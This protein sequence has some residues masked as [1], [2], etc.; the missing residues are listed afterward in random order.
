M[1]EA[2]TRKALID[3]LLK[4]AGWDVADH[5]LVG[6]EIPVAGE[7]AEPWDGVTDY[8]LKDDEGKIL[9]VV[10]AKRSSRHPQDAKEQLRRYIHDIARMQ[11]QYQPFGFMTNGRDIWFWDVQEGNPRRVAGFFTK[12][13]LANR[14]FLREN[15][16]PFRDVEVSQRIVDRPYQHE[17]IRR[18]TEAFE[19]G[20]RRALIVMATGAGK[21]RTTMGLIDLCIRSHQ[22]RNVL[23]LADRDALVDQALKDG[24]KPYLPD[25]PRDRIYSRHID[26]T[27]RL[28]VATEQTMNIVY[29]EFSPGFF[30]LIVLDE[31]HRSIFKRFTEVVD[32]FDARMVGLTA[33]PATY[34]DRNSFRVFDCENTPTFLYAYEDAVRDGYL[35]DFALYK[36]QTGFQRSG[37]K[38]A[39]LSEE[40][41]NA[42]IERGIDPDDIDYSGSDLEKRVS[43]KDTLRKQWQEIMDLV[44]K[45]QSGQLPAK[46][47]VFSITQ[48]HAN[49][50]RDVFEEMYPQFKDLVQVIT[51]SVERVRDGSYGDGLLTKFKNNDKPRIAISVDML[52][53]GVDVPEVVNLVFMKPVQSSI[54]LWQMI[55][56]GTRSQAACRFLERLPEGKKKDFRIIDFW[57]NRFNKK[58][59]DAPPPE[60]PVLVR[61]FNTRLALVEQTISDTRNPVYQQAVT[62]L[63]QM[64]QRISIESFP[65]RKV[66]DQVETAW[67]EGFWLMLTPSKIEFLRLNIGPLLR[68]VPKVDPAAEG[69]TNRIEGVRLKALKGDLSP[70]ALEPAIEDISRLPDDIITR[71][72]SRRVLQEVLTIDAISEAP[73]RLNEVIDT[74]A[75]HMNRRRQRVNSFLMLDL[76]DKIAFSGLI[77]IGDGGK[78]VYVEEYKKQVEERILMI[79]EN[80]PVIQAIRQGDEPNRADL[81]ELER[82]LHERLDDN[83]LHL[84]R[85]NIRRIY[86]YQVDGFLGFLGRVMQIEGLPDYSAVVQN[87]FTDFIAQ[88]KFSADQIRFLRAVQDV[89]LQKR[90]LEEADLYEAPLTSF[91]INA[92][93][94]FFSQDQIE[95]IIKL[96][97]ELAA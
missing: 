14:K 25:E 87:S 91:G 70:D 96:T 53:T 7:D 66:W 5:S 31:A 24:I 44:Y 1:N 36:A 8:I 23:F 83:E 17:A 88:N 76:Q 95:S 94:K 56:R 48:Q 46:T 32:Y 29:K 68:Y 62:S 21:T 27:K 10:E 38:G 28:F 75:R 51:S 64:I 37:I 72:E 65:V 41:R 86:G 60:I 15:K 97:E 85:E 73:I 92:A 89:F 69:F 61:T 74:F 77:S 80:S 13:D 16:I 40:D 47:I 18:V 67:S 50:L 82:Q 9:A 11:N 12:E 93:E 71:E 59:D 63:R 90:K 35:V 79:I 54:K 2:Q 42:L 55:G 34:I 84:N 45:D 22:A 49:R 26:K 33:T 58:F 4:K 3:P 81:I 20:K 43:N 78:Q 57:E 39:D 19:L 52:D 30:D 6:T